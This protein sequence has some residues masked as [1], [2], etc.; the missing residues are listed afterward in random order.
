VSWRLWAYTGET[1]SD[2]ATSN[3]P[4]HLIFVVATLS[5]PGPAGNSPQVHQ[6]LIA[7]LASEHEAE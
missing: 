2:A 7:D 1:I 3:A 4:D 5:F 6:D